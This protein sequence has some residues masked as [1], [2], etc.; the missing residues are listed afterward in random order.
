MAV[1]G[2][3]CCVQVFSRLQ[4]A[5]A[6][7]SSLYYAGFKWWRFPLLESMGSSATCGLQGSWAWG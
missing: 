1:L 7:L 5:G 2:L 6:T 4:R 3:C